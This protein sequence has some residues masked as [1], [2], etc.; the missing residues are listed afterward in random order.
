MT[1]TRTS[2]INRKCL[3]HIA[4]LHACSDFHFSMKHSINILKL[5]INKICTCCLWGVK[6]FQ[7]QLLTDLKYKHY[8]DAHTAVTALEILTG[9]AGG[10]VSK[11]GRPTQNQ[12]AAGV[13][14]G[15][16]Y[17]AVWISNTWHQFETQ[18]GHDGILFFFI[19]LIHPVL[20]I[21]ICEYGSEI[22]YVSH[23]N[24]EDMHFYL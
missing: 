22:Q 16:I 18:P 7:S 17:S 14:A 20:L 4:E 2:F 15:A 19:F 5:K 13:R 3:S 23:P 24:R 1:K 10:F 6:T 21:L 9:Q 11:L 12:P 8:R